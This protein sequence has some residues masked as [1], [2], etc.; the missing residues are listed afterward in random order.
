MPFPWEIPGDPERVSNR[1]ET[2]GQWLDRRLRNLFVLN[3]Y[4]LVPLIGIAAVLAAVV[5]ITLFS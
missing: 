3:L 1:D 5:L 4:H 2:F